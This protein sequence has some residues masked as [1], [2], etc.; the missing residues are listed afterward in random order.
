MV[1]IVKIKDISRA[2]G[3][4]TATV[5]KALN[6]YKDIGE[7]TAEHIRK[8]AKEMG[9]LPNATARALKTNRSNNLGVLFVDRTQSGLTHEYFSK[10][11]N[12]LKDEAERLGF[13]ITFISKDIGEFE[14]SYLEHCR[15]RRCDGVVVACVNFEDPAVVELVKSDIPTVT[16]DHVFDGRTAIISDN[17][18]SMSELVRYAYGLGH[19]RIA[20]IH[21]ERTSVTQKR[22]A[23]FYKTCDEL[24]L[25]IP[26]E[27][28]REA[29]Y[30]DPK[31][32]ALATEALLSLN[33]RPTLI[34]YPD[35]FS[36]IGGRTAIEKH[37]LSIPQDISAVGYDGILLSQV[38]R[39]RLTTWKQDT[40]TIGREAAAKLIEAIN[41]PKTVI[42][43]Q[44]VVPGE[45]IEGGTVKSLS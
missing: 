22:L 3:V 39:P 23:S 32:S 38:L 14:M 34:M 7:Q 19:R 29:I 16:I 15:Y 18:N 9:Y 45:L 1:N 40:D 6:G 10:V 44:V 26:D 28:V 27:Y 25:N 30:H 5:S 12:S 35:D 8:V 17:I 11:L 41:N 42:T 31:S 2:C 20:F 37:G 24:G 36:Y 43:Q 33:A 21:G 13:D 4:S